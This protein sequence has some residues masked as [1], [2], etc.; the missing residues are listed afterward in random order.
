MCCSPRSEKAEPR[1]DFSPLFVGIISNDSLDRSARNEYHQSMSNRNPQTCPPFSLKDQEFLK[2]LGITGL[3]SGLDYALRQQEAAKTAKARIETR[4]ENLQF[5]ELDE[6][7][8]AKLSD[9]RG[10]PVAEL[11]EQ[12]RLF[13]DLEDKTREDPS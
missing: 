1:G 3:S 4:A 9:E 12:L 2:E 10:I 5:L 11:R 6:S 8:L 13:R 7:A